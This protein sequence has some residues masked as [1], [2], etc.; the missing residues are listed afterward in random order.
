MRGNLQLK[1][2]F[3]LLVAAL[4]GLSACNRNDSV[5]AAREDER[6]PAL[7]ATPAEQDFMMKAAQTHLAEIDM[8][9]I[10]MQKT[11]NSDVKD[12]ANM[13]QK[14]HTHAQL[15]HLGP[16]GLRDDHGSH[17]QTISHRE[18]GGNTE[19]QHLCASSVSSVW[20]GWHDFRS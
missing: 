5:Q 19:P 12:F 9:R 18:Q 2:C 16:A 7:S 6:S 15:Q 11:E 4:F 20:T 8:A 3:L 17:K 14:D 1:I 13:I 10:V